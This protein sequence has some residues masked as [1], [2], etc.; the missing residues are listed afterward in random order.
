[1]ASSPS[2]AEP[3]NLSIPRRYCGSPAATMCRRN[4]YG[5]I[6]WRISRCCNPENRASA[7]AL[8]SINT[9]GRPFACG[10]ALAAHLA[11]GRRLMDNLCR[12]AGRP[13]A[14][15]YRYLRRRPWSHAGIVAFVLAAV[16]CSVTTQYGVKFLVDTLAGNQP[17]IWLAFLA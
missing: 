1:M 14:F 5:I 17:G 11:R 15:V 8:Q 12:Y 10:R 2:R 6:A 13:I 3:Q 4:S 9:G 7:C 16:A